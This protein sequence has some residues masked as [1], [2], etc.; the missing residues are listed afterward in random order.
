[1]VFNK[2]ALKNHVTKCISITRTLFK[3]NNNKE[4]LYAK[5]IEYIKNKNTDLNKISPIFKAIKKEI[6]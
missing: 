3:E 4:E 1:M 5:L 6:I 2:I